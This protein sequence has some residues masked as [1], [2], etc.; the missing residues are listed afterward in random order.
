[1]KKDVIMMI[2]YPISSRNLFWL[3]WMIEQKNGMEKIVVVWH[4]WFEW[5]EIS[6]LDKERLDK[7]RLMVSKEREK[8]VAKF[9]TY[10][11]YFYHQYART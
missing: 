8:M 7:K 1:M 4:L 10:H 2:I 11:R 3:E 9:V 6:L 5:K